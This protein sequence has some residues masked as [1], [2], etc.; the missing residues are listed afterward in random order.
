[1]KLLT[2]WNPVQDLDVMQNRLSDAFFRSTVAN[3]YNADS[4][5]EPVADTIEDEKEYH[6]ALEL[7]GLK[8]E[9]IDVK[10]DGE[11]LLVSGER[12]LP[13][14]DSKRKY[15]RIERFYGNFSR[16]FR[17]PEN[18]D[19]SK[20]SAEFRDGLLQVSIAKKEEAQPKLIE[21]KIK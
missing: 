1:M 19:R 10:V 18:A 21:I 14:D 11:W 2:T 8:R 13:A 5:W 17:I 3:G 9:D 20:V 7:P 16:R 6:V 4:P 12:K 15:R